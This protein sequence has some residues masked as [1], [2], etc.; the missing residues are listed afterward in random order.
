[1]HWNRNDPSQTSAEWVWIRRPS[2]E[3]KCELEEL[4]NFNC[5]GL[6][7]VCC[8]YTHTHNCFTALWI[9]SR[10]TCMSR[11]QK[12][13]S[14]TYTYRDHQSSSICFL[15]ILRSITSSLFNLRAWQSF[16]TTSLQVIFDLP[17]GLEPATSYSIHF[18][19]QSLSSFHNTSPYQRNLFCCS[20]VIMS[21]N[22]SLSLNST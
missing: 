1:M 14:P 22:P 4:N 3:V 16:C 5:N 12:K 20:N 8:R 13:H 11:Y 21:S 17:L 7:Y 10:T 9:L 6:K 2:S 18:F 19:T 15:H